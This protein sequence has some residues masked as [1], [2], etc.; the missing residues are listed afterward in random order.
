MTS[1]CYDKLFFTDCD[2]NLHR[3]NK[4]A[5]SELH[6]GEDAEE[7]ELRIERFKLTKARPTF[8]PVPRQH[9]SWIFLFLDTAETSLAWYANFC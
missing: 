2:S 4:N 1:C 3:P 8:L 7:A 5:D 9:C 6:G